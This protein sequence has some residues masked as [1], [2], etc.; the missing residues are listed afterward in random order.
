M[1]L[2]P[3]MAEDAPMAAADGE[4]SAE[5]TPVFAQHFAPLEV[6][7][8]AVGGAKLRAPTGRLSAGGAKGAP[9]LGVRA[10]AS[11]KIAFTDDPSAAGALVAAANAA[12]AQR[13][14]NAFDA[15]PGA[16]AAALPAPWDVPMFLSHS[17]A[18]QRVPAKAAPAALPAPSPLVKRLLAP[19]RD[20]LIVA[21]SVV[22]RG[23]GDVVSLLGCFTGWRE[24]VPMVA[25][26][27]GAHFVTV[28]LRAGEYR[29][30]FEVNGRLC[31][32]DDEPMADACGA[33][34]PVP[35]A[36]VLLVDDGAEFDGEERAEAL[37]RADDPLGAAPWLA[38]ASDAAADGCYTQSTPTAA[39]GLWVP[40]LPPHLAKLHGVRAAPLSLRR[41]PRAGQP[42]V[43][44]HSELG[45]VAFALTAAPPRAKFG[46]AQGEMSED[47]NYAD[48]TSDDQSM[49]SAPGSRHGTPLEPAPR[50]PPPAL[51]LIHI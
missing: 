32:A 25:D 11:R 24:R 19:S 34:A 31:V 9:R 46:E 5:T 27:S 33:G 16:A 28:H 50:A 42:P 40:Q 41:A 7:K 44:W 12:L 6:V 37:S 13:L 30:V 10:E 1:F 48:S 8:A 3:H 45:H 18:L 14:P 38:R 35:A 23:G 36:N 51:S 29:Y 22:W 43:E 15:F 20:R 17:H 4:A 47:D 39:L 49:P 21:V 2:V 26:G